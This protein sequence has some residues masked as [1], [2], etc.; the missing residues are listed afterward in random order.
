MTKVDALDNVHHED[1]VEVRIDNVK[2]DLE[3]NA[4]DDKYDD[5]GMV[6][7]EGLDEEEIDV[8]RMD[9]ISE[10]NARAPPNLAVERDNI[11]LQL[12]KA[13]KQSQKRRELWEKTKTLPS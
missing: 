11:S 1:T 12:K 4:V 8:A 7:N 13:I 2:Y 3:V 6:A 5:N 9:S 10:Q